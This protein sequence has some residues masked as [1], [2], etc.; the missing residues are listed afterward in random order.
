MPAK[1]ALFVHEDQ[2]IRIVVAVG[3]SGVVWRKAM[4]I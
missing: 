2:E 3:V 1:G 4:D